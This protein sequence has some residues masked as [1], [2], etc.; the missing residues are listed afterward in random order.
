M[1]EFTY[2]ITFSDGGTYSGIESGATFSLKIGESRKFSG[3][4]AGVL[5]KVRAI[6][7][8]P[9]WSKPKTRV[10]EVGTAPQTMKLKSSYSAPRW[11]SDTSM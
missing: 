3:I 2:K 1:S 7:S 6:D 8:A 9:G 10:L 4:P 5:V 11:L